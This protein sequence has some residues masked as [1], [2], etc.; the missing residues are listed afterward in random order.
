MNA[1]GIARHYHELTAE[2]RFALTLN[3]VAR[4][5]DAE[6]NRLSS[7]ASRLTLSV[8]HDT[9]Y[10]E[11]YVEIRFAVYIELQ[12]LAAAYF[13]AMERH[14]EHDDM[15]TPGGDDEDDGDEDDDDE[16]GDDGQ[17]C[18][19]QSLNDVVLATGH[20]LRARMAAWLHWCKRRHLPPLQSWDTMPGYD[21]LQSA[22]DC[23]EN[24]AHGL[25]AAFTPMGMM[26]WLN[27]ARPA[28]EPELTELPCAPERYADAL[29]SMFQARVR[30]HGGE[31]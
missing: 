22:L 24:G 16:Q 25:G 14:A 4:G 28:G 6:Q 29:E 26:R 12:D 10:M 31:E 1:N 30:F 18:L 13:D 21:R 7:S 19:W 3:A 8:R 11:A 20:L 27:R 2:E 9:P 17:R 23:V 5:D 15:E